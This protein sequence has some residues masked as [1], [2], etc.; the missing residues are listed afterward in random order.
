[1]LA[2][3]LQRSAA[4][5]R[6][7]VGVAAEFGID[8]RSVL[9]GTGLTARELAD[10]HLEIRSGQ[11][12]QV[13]EN[14]VGRLGDESEI[15]LVAGTRY[16]LGLFGMIGFACMSS[17][18]LRG[19]IDVTIRYQD[20]LFTLARA[21]QVAGPES[22]QLEIDASLLPTAIQRFAVD[23]AIA[24]AWTALTDLNGAPL[25]GA[26]I[27]IA[28]PRPAYAGRYRELLGTAPA[29][30]AEANFIEIDNALLDRPRVATDPVALEL[31]ERDCRALLARRAAEGGVRGLVYDRLSRAS[32]VVPSMTLVAADLNMSVRT[33]RRQLDLE[34]TSFREIEQRVRRERAEALLE[35]PALTLAAIADRLGYWSESGFLRAFHRWHGMT[36][37]R[38]RAGLVAEK[39]RIAASMAIADTTASS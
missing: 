16:S 39:E 24:T 28:H 15:G 8:T 17:P 11:E 33:V 2:S 20:L 3:H 35:D 7:L 14:I 5:A 37:G 29:F 26:H 30:E 25:T 9:R 31:C 19:T 18:T 32:G 23:H 13:I 27:G 12:Q 22:T 6:L 36:P 10:P 34:H 21:D 38:W 4:S 1:M